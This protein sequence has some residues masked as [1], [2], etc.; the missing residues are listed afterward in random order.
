LATTNFKRL[1]IDTLT[2]NFL[3]LK[4]KILLNKIGRGIGITHMDEALMPHE[5]GMEVMGHHDPISYGK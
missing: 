5:Q 3:S 4:Y 1:N 2:S